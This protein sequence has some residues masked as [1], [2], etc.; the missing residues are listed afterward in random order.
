MA[1][2]PFDL[3]RFVTAQRPVFGAVQ[4]ELAAGA[5]RTHWMWFVFP[6]MKGLGASAM[7][8]HYG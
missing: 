2:E 6:Q 1:T 5:K 8:S 7:A 4:A 3:E